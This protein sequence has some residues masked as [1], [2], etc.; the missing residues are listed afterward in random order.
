[1]NDEE[2]ESINIH[3]S[4]SE[5]LKKIG[6]R[7]LIGKAFVEQNIGREV[8][9]ATMEKIWKVNKPLAFRDL[10]SNHFGISFAN[11]R[12]KKKVMWGC[13]WLFDSHLFGLMPYIGNAQLQIVDFFHQ[14]F[15]IHMSKLPLDC[16]NRKMGE[17][18]GESVECVKEVEVDGDVA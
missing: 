17:M 3:S 2:N 11:R 15:W 9:R 16:M 1:M 6:D 10:G 8:I 13:P 14:C 5:G 12:N 18:L 7:S 4:E